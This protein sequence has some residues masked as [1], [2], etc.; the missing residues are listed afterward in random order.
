MSEK[1]G[2]ERGLKSLFFSF[3]LFILERTALPRAASDDCSRS[4]CSPSPVPS[5]CFHP[6]SCLP[7]VCS[8]H[9][10]CL[11]ALPPT[12][13][14]QPSSVC[15]SLALSCCRASPLHACLPAP[16]KPSFRA[17]PLTCISPA[18]PCSATPSPCIPPARPCF[19][20]PSPAQPLPV[21]AQPSSQPSSPSLA[22]W[23][24]SGAVAPFFTPRLS[25]RVQPL[26][27]HACAPMT[28]SLPLSTPLTPP[29]LHSRCL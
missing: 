19:A 11:C 14:V 28:L 10:R 5:S 16:A 26:P 4:P 29:C 17:S 27:P 15:V 8:F 20:T 18:P 23:R 2:L 9:P 13:A 6:G 12:G 24:H 22:S 25:S 1:T 3:A 7:H 21:L